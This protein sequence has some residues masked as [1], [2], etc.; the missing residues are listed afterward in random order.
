LAE[1]LEK[2]WDDNC[3]KLRRDIKEDTRTHIG[4]LGD[5]LNKHLREDVDRLGRELRAD[6]RAN[7]QKDPIGNRKENS[8]YLRSS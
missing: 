4:I 5:G 7:F 1:G 6:L 8:R 2:K 3:M